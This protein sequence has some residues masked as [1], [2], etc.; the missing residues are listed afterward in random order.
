[1][2]TM[3]AKQTL[4][5]NAL[6]AVDAVQEKMRHHREAGR[7]ALADKFSVELQKAWSVHAFVQGLSDEDAETVVRLLA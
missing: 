2:T 7:S 1:M 4:V 6:D 3:T 5:N